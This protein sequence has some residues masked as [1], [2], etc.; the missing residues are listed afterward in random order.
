M[1]MI[2]HEGGNEIIAVI[3]ALAHVEGEIDVRCG[4]GVLQQMRAQ[5]LI[6][7]RVCPALVYQQR[8][9]PGA[10]L[11]QGDCIMLSPRFAVVA[12]IS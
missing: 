9:D 2:R 6:Q 7:K 11:D 8:A 4:A 3:I 12:E 1:E 5:F 10:I